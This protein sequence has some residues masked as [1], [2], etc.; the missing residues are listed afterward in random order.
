MKNHSGLS[1]FAIAAGTL[2]A[3]I[4]IAATF[5]TLMG[6]F[7]MVLFNIVS[8]SFGGPQLDLG[9]SVAFVFLLDL[10]RRLL[11]GQRIQA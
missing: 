3:L 5:Y 9:V 7:F 6:F 2:A 10:I 4:A 11:F 1:L 8:P